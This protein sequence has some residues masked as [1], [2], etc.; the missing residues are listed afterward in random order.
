MTQTKRVCSCG[1]PE[2]GFEC[3][4]DFLARWPGNLDFTCEFC[5]VYTASRPRCN[6]CQQE[7]E[8]AT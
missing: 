7:E 1:N 3:I 6:Y 2:M 4:C 5:G 8:C